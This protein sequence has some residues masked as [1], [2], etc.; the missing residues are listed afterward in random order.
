MKQTPK[1]AAGTTLTAVRTRWAFVHGSM[2]SGSNP[3]IA[4]RLT[5]VVMRFQPPPSELLSELAPKREP[6][7]TSHFPCVPN[8]SRGWSLKSLL[9]FTR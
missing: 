5:T 6:N 9:L 2:S 3:A 8:R 1:T 4:H 7:P